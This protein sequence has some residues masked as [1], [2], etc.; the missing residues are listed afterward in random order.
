MGMEGFSAS[1]GL[2]SFGAKPGGSTITGSHQGTAATPGA[3]SSQ[4]APPGTTINPDGTWKA[5]AGQART[6]VFDPS[7]YSGDPGP[8][9]SDQGVQAG[10][11]QGQ[12]Q[13]LD[14]TQYSPAEQQWRDQGS[15]YNTP[16][17]G[18]TN[19][20]SIVQNAS[21]NRPQQVNN[22]Q[23]YF[24][25]FQKPIISQ[26]PGFGAYFDN[27]KDRVGESIN[28]SSAATGTYG[29]SSA[30]DQTARAFTDLEGQRALKEA[31]YNLARIGEDRAWEGL[32]GSLAGQADQ[33]GLANSQDQR[34][35][36]EMLSRLGI[37]SQRLGLDR[38]NAGFDAANVAGNAE[39]T[40]GQDYFNN[41]AASGD[42][43]ADLIRSI[44]G[45]ALDN[46]ASL[47]GVENSGGVAMGNAGLANETA[48][49][50]GTKD[51]L[52]TGVTVYT[53]PNMPWNQPR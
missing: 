19:T 12:M 20:Q 23:A 7:G 40:R 1:F 30:N 37:D 21:A 44:M 39:R 47:F 10:Q 43:F 53:D 41:Q 4:W 52:A 11:T 50:A 16:G 22:S 6:G 32:G 42:R 9:V 33:Q 36:D 2:P 27:A 8:Y 29:S 13:G 17:F 48:N 31:D 38:T 35:W 34:G 18:E 28:R 26:E 5:P 15:F 14:F 46:D 49:A 24:D 45:P 25:Q 3:P 51:A